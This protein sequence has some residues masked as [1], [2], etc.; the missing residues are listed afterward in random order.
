MRIGIMGAMTEEVDSIHSH[1]TNVKEFEH[2][3]RKY[4]I[5]NINSH[6]VVLVFS[7]WG[8][9]AS[10]A[11]VTSLITEFKIDHL[12]FTGVA[13][14]A[15]PSLNIGDIVVSEQLY[16]HDMDARPLFK[17]HQ[18][19]LT[20]I[21]FFQADPL[22][23]EK[24]HRATDGL[25]ASLTAKIPAESL[26]RFNIREPKCRFG[27]IATGDQFIY[28]R[29]RTEAILADVPETVAVEMEGGAVAQVCNDYKIPFVV[30]RTI[31][32]K[33]DHTS[34][35]DFPAFINEVARHYSEHIV[36]GMLRL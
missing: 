16:Q 7:R 15:D 33:A 14:A 24:A 28:S 11:T 22:L 32:D 23:K 19:P 10:A 17:K 5:G 29:E 18:I 13:G 6:E 1:M 25:F 2:G 4:Y 8:K 31:S 3:D 26:A 34:E 12:I 9:V 20:K 36:T 21:T 27:T 35:I 30:I